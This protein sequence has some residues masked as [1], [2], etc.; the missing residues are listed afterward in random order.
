MDNF[1]E[2]LVQKKPDESD[3][4]KK[5]LVIAGTILFTTL[6]G[7]VGVATGWTFLLIL[8]AAAAVGAY[9]LVINLQVEYE[10]CV[11][12]DELDVDKILAKS[13]RRH[14]LTAQI[15]KFTYFGTVENAP[16]LPET[17]T[18]VWAAD[19]TGEGEWCADTETEEYGATRLVFTPNEK[20]R[21]TI[22]ESL[23]ASLRKNL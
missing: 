10:Y 7:W 2:Q 18:L 6:V 22:G 4:R 3:L 13:K 12:N 5:I 17:T 19:G 11:T 20:I 16:D 8:P 15:R 1:A 23:P 14:L 21:A 9:Y